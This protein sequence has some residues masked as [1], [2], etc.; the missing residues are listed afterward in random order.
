MAISEDGHVRIGHD[1]SIEPAA[2]LMQSSLPELSSNYA[3]TLPKIQTGQGPR[4][5][6]ANMYIKF[7]NLYMM[8][9]CTE[10]YSTLPYNR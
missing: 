2:S 3:E 7:A 1:G 4:S 5:R 10:A 6:A 8:E 9:C